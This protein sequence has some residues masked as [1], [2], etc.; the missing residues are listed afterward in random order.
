[1]D[2]LAS[3]KATSDGPVALRLRGRGRRR[4]RPR[5]RRRRRLI[6]PAARSP[7][8][9]ASTVRR[10]GRQRAS[11]GPDIRANLTSVRGSRIAGRRPRGGRASRWWCPSRPARSSRR[12]GTT[13][14]VRTPKDGCSPQ[15]QCGCCTVLVDG[16]P[17]VA[18]V[19]PVRRVAGR[20]ITTI[21]GPRRRRSARPGPTR[22]APP[23]PASAASAP[24]ASSC[25]SP[26]CGP[27]RRRGRGGG[28]PG[29][30]GPPVPVHR[31]A[32]DLRRLGP[33]SARGRRRR[34]RRAIWRRR[35]GGPRSRV[36]ARSGSAPD[37]ALG[38]GG[39]ADDSAPLDALVAVPDGHGGWSVGETLAEARAAAGQG[40]GPAHDRRGRAAARAARRATGRRRCGRPGSSR[41]T[42]RPTRPGACPAAS[43][44]P[45]SPTAAPSAARSRRRSTDGGE[46][47]GRPARPAGAGAALARGHR[48]HGPEATADRGGPRAGT[49]RAWCGRSTRRVWPR[50]SR[51]WPPSSC[52]RTCR[53]PVRRPRSTSGRRDGP[54]SALLRAGL[55]GAAGPVRSPD[56][57]GRRGVGRPTVASRCGCACGDPLDEVVL[58]SYCIG[59]AHMALGWVTSEGLAV[60]ADG[61]VHDLT[62]RSF[63]IVRA[64]D[65]PVIEVEIEPDTGPPVNGSDA[66]FAAVAAAALGRPRMPD[67]PARYS[68]RPPRRLTMT[69]PTGLPY[70][71]AVRAGDW[72]IVSGQIGLVDGD[73]VSGGFDAELAQA[74]ANLE[75]R[76]AE[77]GRDDGR[78]RE[79]DRVPPAH[80]RLPAHERAST[81]RPSPSP[82]RPAPRSPSPSSRSARSS[83]SRRGRSPGRADRAMMRP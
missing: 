56:G 12:C 71:P 34:T 62:I 15:G 24:R 69:N 48:A 16:S 8:P 10:L 25:G 30:V 83:R 45:R 33:R 53:C 77:V 35:A 46:D 61:T 27:R 60:D 58:R 44:R 31:V 20:R 13:L 14:G 51:R 54:R 64:V 42:S 23:G 11:G 37:V 39:F 47:A 32:D 52:S 73:L 19:T 26:G 55:A 43:R 65:T 80:E 38:E 9:P 63:G 21:D 76:L 79:D 57:R 36:A 74:L 4:H 5:S 70:T 40:A 72:V 3:K 41:R 6:S 29:P 66:V 78:R 49:D 2:A 28:G 75:A 18:C 59:A 68:P 50:S 67:R 22:S 81:P 17:R 7:A 82:V 1:M